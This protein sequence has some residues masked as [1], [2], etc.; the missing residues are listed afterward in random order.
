M[1]PLV[2]AILAASAISAWAAEPDAAEI[3]RAARM[4]PVGNPVALD[5]QLRS[6]SQTVPFRI[7]VDGAVRYQF[8]NPSQE[9]ILELAEDGSKLSER[10]GGKESPVRPA[11]YDD[12]VRGSDLSYEDIALKFLYWDRPAII[13]DETVTTR[14]A[15]KIE[16]QAPRGTSQ[17]GVA[18][19]WIDKKNGALMRVE[20]YDLKGRLV[21]RFE[22]RSAH[23]IDDQWMLKQMRVE[24]FDP[25][26]K[27]I[28]GRTYLEVL[29]KTAPAA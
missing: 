27:K 17:Y 20:G 10:A 21:R 2:F 5:A 3:L 28:T 14:D 25:E 11:R 4:N 9:I 19:L 18:R 29:G 22:V 6:G 15:W 12:R 7:V 26:T 1:K 13:G 24:T 16:V 8:D 23:K